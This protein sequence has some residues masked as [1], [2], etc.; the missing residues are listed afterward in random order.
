M[1]KTFSGPINKLRLLLL[2]ITALIGL[3]TYTSCISDDITTSPS[4]R[5][6]FSTDTVSFD[7]VF[8]GQGTPTAR[9]IVFNRSKQGVNISSIRFSNPQTRFSM[10]VDGVSGKSFSNVEI[11]GGDSIYVF[12]ECHPEI[13]DSDFPV[14]T[15]DELEFVTNGNTQRVRVEAWG[16]DVVRLKGLTVESDMTLTAERPYVI[17]DSLVVAPQAVLT[18]LPGARVLFHDKAR[19]TVHG[20]LDAVGEFDRFIDMRGDRLDNVLPDVGYDIM[21]GQWEGVR[22]TAGSFNN[23]MEYVNMRSTRS[24]ITVDSTADLSKS[25]LL[26]RNCWLHNSQNNVLKASYAAIQAYGVCFSEAA[27]AVVSLTGGDNLFV[28]CTIANN[29]LF[30]A[31]S[32]PLLSLYHCLPEKK[33]ETDQP[34]MKGSF[35]NCIIYGL[36]SSINQGDLSGSEVWLRNVLLKEEGSDDEHFV[37]C[38]WNE[39]PLFYTERSE[40]YFNYRLRSDSP[41]IKKGNPEYVT[42]EVLYDMDNKDRLADGNP[43]DLGAYVYI[44]SAE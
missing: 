1:F 8:S 35:E 33:E 18:I 5:L 13:S 38:V 41:A 3:I 11:R 15:E 17:F 6:A 29:Y 30:S 40:Y 37:S 19:L 25:K 2:T 27:D 26:L 23:R 21:A 39:D 22:F 14:L 44:P 34:L 28:Q 31:I 7:T 42:P 24:G 9:L 16:Q 32:A 20:R 43:P 36:A 4:V 10:N 12:I